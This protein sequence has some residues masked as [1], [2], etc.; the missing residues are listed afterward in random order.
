MLLLETHSM[1]AAFN[2][3]VE[4][5]LVNT[6]KKGESALLLWRTGRTVMLGRNQVAKAEINEKA[7]DA[8]GVKVVRRHSG[9]GAIYTDPG[10]LLYSVIAPYDNENDVRA[11]FYESIVAPII[12]LL[13]DMGVR[14]SFEGRNDIVVAGRKV[15]GLAQFIRNGR[16]CSH[17]S[18]LYDADLEMLS[19][20]LNADGEKISGKALRSVRS[21]V[22]NLKEFMHSPPSM[23]TF[24]SRVKARLS[25]AGAVPRALSETDA[26]AARSIQ[27]ARFDK[28]EW[29]YG[30]APRYSFKNSV[31][32]PGGRIE[33]YADV[34]DGLIEDCRIMGDFLGLSPIG[35]LESLL[36]GVRFDAASV[37]VALD[38]RRGDLPRYL[39]GISAEE[40]LACMF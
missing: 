8:H 35:E 15:S 18:L 9:G 31:R 4:E 39:G 28:P 24:C 38:S 5:H 2:F 25:A 37:A 23:E 12:A 33:V 19:A 7:A 1:D 11:I 32:F 16:I 14:A 26:E 22:A 21:R 13:G 29:T 30:S 6:L 36:R 10:V 40:L 3:S 17:A 27:K 20:V 34:K